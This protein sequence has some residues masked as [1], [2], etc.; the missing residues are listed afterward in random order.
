MMDGS[1]RVSLRNRRFLSKIDPVCQKIN[2]PPLNDTTAPAPSDP[3]NLPRRSERPRQERKLFVAKLH[4][5]SH[6]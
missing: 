5:P 4:G 6:G 3:L 1:R 2:D